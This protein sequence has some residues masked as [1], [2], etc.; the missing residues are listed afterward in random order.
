MIK[1]TGK[2]VVL[3]TDDIKEHLTVYEQRR[4]QAMCRKIIKVREAIGKGNN[5]YY[6]INQDEP[7]ADLILDI[8]IEGE[9]T[10]ERC[11]PYVS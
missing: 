4:F 8:I 5:K 9:E 1:I 6:I 7:Y 3:K 11:D 10:K 2:F